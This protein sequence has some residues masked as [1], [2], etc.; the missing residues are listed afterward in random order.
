M[1]LKQIKN[2][3]SPSLARIERELAKV[4]AQ[5]LNFWVK[6]TPKRS[7]NARR[8]TKLVGDT[9]QAR[10]PYAQRLD[11]GLSKQAPEGMSKPTEEFIER[12]LKSIIGKK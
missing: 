10:Y 6:T 5:A 1:S 11:E 9:I 2:S 8:R 3:I 12:R 4:P 7:G